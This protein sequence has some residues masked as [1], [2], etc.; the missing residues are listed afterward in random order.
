MTS[1]GENSRTAN[2]WL[3]ADC[4]AT[5]VNAVADR[6][7]PDQII[8]FGSAARGEMTEYSDIDLLVIN[9]HRHPEA[10]RR[11]RMRLNGDRIDVVQMRRDDVERQRRTA[12][13][14]QEAALSQGITVLLKS[15]GRQAV[16][17]G[18][19]W[20]TDESGIVKSSKLKPNESARFPQERR[21][22]LARQ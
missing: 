18:Q 13:T 2:G 20:F 8:L 5:A 16:A 17:T 1:D 10:M 12:A 14:L 6:Y 11:E 21:I 15:D 3:E 19:S 22:P 4:L 7:D 9:D